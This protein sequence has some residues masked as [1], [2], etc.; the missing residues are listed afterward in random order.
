MISFFSM[1][2]S[3]IQLNNLNRHLAFIFL[4]VGVLFFSSCASIIGGADY[5]ANIEVDDEKAK[6]YY[7]GTFVGTGSGTVMVKRKNANKFT[8]TIN[9]EGCETKRY[10]YYTRTFRGWAFVGSLFGWTFVINQIYLPI[11]IAVDLLNGAYWKPNLMERGITKINYKTYKY[12][13]K[14]PNCSDKEVPEEKKLVWYDLVYLKNGSIIKGNINEIL[15]NV[16]VKITTKD[17]SLF[18]Y[19]FDEIEKIT[20]EKSE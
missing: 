13:V 11:G 14:Y 17:G 1:Q 10:S 18:V 16:H 2:L 20:K 6:I 3:S 8:F 15:P 19:K 12:N 4:T 7:N 9:K 5:R